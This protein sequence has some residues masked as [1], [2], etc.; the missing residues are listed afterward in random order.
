MIWDYY[1]LPIVLVPR[2]DIARPGC[3]HWGRPSDFLCSLRLKS[4]EACPS[5]PSN[6]ITCVFHM[7]GV[8]ARRGLTPFRF[9]SQALRIRRLQHTFMTFANSIALVLT[10]VQ[11]LS[12]NLHSVCMLVVS[13]YDI[14]PA[15]TAWPFT[16]RLV[17]A[18][19][20]VRRLLAV[21]NITVSVS[22]LCCCC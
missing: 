8:G 4:L 10:E 19:E 2:L 16:F 9:R 20:S 11:L 13:G 6:A 18:S 5:S 12:S 15:V 21:R 7:G 17:T 1:S 22:F 3:R 14:L